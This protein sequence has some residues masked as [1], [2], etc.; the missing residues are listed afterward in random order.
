MK[1]LVHLFSS[2][3][4]AGFWGTVTIS[5]QDGHPTLVRKEEQIKLERK[6][7]DTS[8]KNHRD[9]H[10]PGVSHGNSGDSGK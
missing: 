7:E 10:A 6:P 8:R 5:F 1:T 2:L 9:F 3:E 4:S